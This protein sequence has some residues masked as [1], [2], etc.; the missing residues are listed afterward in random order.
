LGKNVRGPDLFG[1]VSLDTPARVRSI[2]MKPRV[3]ALAAV[4]AVILF[5]AVPL[6]AHHSVAMYDLTHQAAV[7]GTVTSFEWTNPHV[8]IYIDVT[9]DKGNV[10]NWFAEGNSP[11]IMSRIG[12]TRNQFKPGDKITAWGFLRKDGG[13]GLRLMKVV[14][15]DGKELLTVDPELF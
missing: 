5:A 2:E 10:R 1:V 7:K 15:P 9:D 11:N 6:R 4:A 13:A 3:L 8:Y 12:W 14:L